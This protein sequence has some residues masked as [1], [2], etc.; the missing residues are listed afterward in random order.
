MLQ[1]LP[2]QA[3]QEEEASRI[4]DQLKQQTENYAIFVKKDS[5]SKK[6][7]VKI[8]LSTP[9]TEFRVLD[10]TLKPTQEESSRAEVVVN[11][12]DVIVSGNEAYQYGNGF[13]Q[14]YLIPNGEM[15]VE[16]RDQ[17]YVIFDGQ[18]VKLSLLN[19]K[20]RDATRGICGQYN[21]NKME[22]FLTPA[23]CFIRDHKKFIET[24]EVEGSC[25]QETRRKL[26]TSN[27]IKCFRKTGPVYVSLVKLSNERDDSRY[28]TKFQTRYVEKGDEICFTVRPMAACGGTCQSTSP[29]E[30]KV[31][32]HCV[33]KSS[34][35]QVW[36]KQIDNG[37]S[38]DFSHKPETRK[39]SMEV[40]QLC[41]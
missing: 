37:G 29:A 35:T 10:I 33:K 20:Y 38:P 31:P 39:E 1:F 34:V 24:Y 36:K 5:D 28:C 23:N 12:E 11:G 18:R 16:I 13:V 30:R 41:A 4:R 19:G 9:E 8:T 14:I 21:D 25:G 26:E 22:E 6:R 17:F 3:R 40:P 27:S 15:K 2:K 7:L 32:V